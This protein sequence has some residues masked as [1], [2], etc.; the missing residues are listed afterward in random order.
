MWHLKSNPALFKFSAL[1][2]IVASTLSCSDRNSISLIVNVTATSI[3]KLPFVIAMDQ[4]LYAKHGLNVEMR[5]PTPESEGRMVAYGNF[6][7]R[8][9]NMLG[10]SES[11]RADISI[12]G[13]NPMI[14][15]VSQA[16]PAAR[17]IIIGATD[18]VV[19]AHVIARKGISSVGE[20]KGRRIGVSSMGATSG[21]QALLFAERMGW[22]PV[23][24]VSILVGYEGIDA[25]L[26]GSLDAIV[27]SENEFADAK[28][29]D[30]PALLDMREWDES[31]A[32]NSIV[33]TPGW[34]E[35]STHREAARRFLIA[36]A[37]A[38]ALFH[39]Q[40]QLVQRVLAEWYGVTDPERARIF[41]ERGAWIPRKPYPCY[42]GIKKGMAVYGSNE[43]RR[44]QPS[45]FYDDSMM[46]EIDA[47]GFIDGL[48]Q[49][50]E[51]T[52]S[53]PLSALQ[54]EKK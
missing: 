25:L 44:Y 38:I 7:G 29:E 22:D 32:G 8:V 10:I 53:A 2:A 54:S 50:G 52:A 17:Q 18:C 30:L 1:L 24:D 27:A 28:R 34:L 39:Q 37:E 31:I 21:F 45:D 19:R 12:Y 35:D 47:S 42:D 3:S 36:T 49:D 46:R 5:L 33:V 48:Y 11:S 9:P 20:L 51:S 23:Q 14:V 4:G 40:P 16:G 41:Y 6:W 13:G 15:R 43:M 26:D